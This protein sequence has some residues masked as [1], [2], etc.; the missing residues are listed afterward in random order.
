MNTSK[1]LRD[2]VHSIATEENERKLSD[3]GM[4]FDYTLII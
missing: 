3:A 1:I 4:E 2:L